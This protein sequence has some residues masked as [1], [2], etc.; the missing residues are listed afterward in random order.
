M[1]SVLGPRSAPSPFDS[2]DKAAVR[3]G[4]CIGWG[5]E[6]KGKNGRRRPGAAAPTGF[7]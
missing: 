4:F 3:R 2:T 5:R 7:N 1:T 6:G